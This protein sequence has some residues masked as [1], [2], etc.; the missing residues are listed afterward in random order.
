MSTD[1]GIDR[2]PEE[3]EAGLAADGGHVI[4][5]RIAARIPEQYRLSRRGGPGSSQETGSV[6]PQVVGRRRIRDQVKTD[7]VRID[8]AAAAETHGAAFVHPFQRRNLHLLPSEFDAGAM[9]D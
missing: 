7:A 2:I 1:D 9:S 4:I 8:F 6:H 3:I 5:P